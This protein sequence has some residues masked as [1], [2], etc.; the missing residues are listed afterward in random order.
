MFAGG[1][2]G[3][4]D[5]RGGDDGGGG[6]RDRGRGGPV[7]FAQAPDGYAGVRPSGATQ[8]LR[9]GPV[10]IV[11]ARRQP[12]TL[13]QEQRAPVRVQQRADVLQDL[14]AQRPDVQLV[15]NVLHL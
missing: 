2:R 5:G 4:G 8:A 12:A 10:V 14:V 11:L 3:H 9:D 15:A 1:D 13:D 6:G 7:V